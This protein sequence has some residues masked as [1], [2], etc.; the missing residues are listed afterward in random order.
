MLIAPQNGIFT[1][2]NL[3]FTISAYYE[4]LRCLWRLSNSFG[5]LMMFS[6]DFEI[7]LVL[8]HFSAIPVFHFIDV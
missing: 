4:F 7:D 1:N 2:F 8:L 5:I 6:I 3:S